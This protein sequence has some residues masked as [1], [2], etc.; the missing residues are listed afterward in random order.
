M[1]KIAQAEEKEA[2]TIKPGYSWK[3][4][5]SIETRTDKLDLFEQTDRRLFF[6]LTGHKIDIEGNYEKIIDY[7]GNS[8]WFKGKGNPSKIEMLSLN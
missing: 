4:Y 5:S 3:T 7:S 2:R 8:F 6:E 1:V